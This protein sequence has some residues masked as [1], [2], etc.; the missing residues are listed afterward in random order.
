MFLVLM[1]SVDQMD[2]R[3]ITEDTVDLDEPPHVCVTDTTDM[4][5][6]LA[7][8]DSVEN[9]A[10]TEKLGKSPR[11]EESMETLWRAGRSFVEI[12][13]RVA[14]GCQRYQKMV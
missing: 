14:Q 13:D 2:V 11:I 10:I 1:A 3:N 4:D 12:L 8:T 7:G 6:I 5:N 9:P